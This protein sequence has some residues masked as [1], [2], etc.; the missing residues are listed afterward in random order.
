MNLGILDAFQPR[1]IVSPHRLVGL[2]LIGLS[3]LCFSL[4]IGANIFKVVEIH[5]FRLDV[6]NNKVPWCSKSDGN[7]VVVS[8][9]DDKCSL[10]HGFL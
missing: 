2:S 8:L 3:L 6:I 10:A 1:C 4:S 7:L 9:V 5:P